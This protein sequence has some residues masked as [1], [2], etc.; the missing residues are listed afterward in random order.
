MVVQLQELFAHVGTW[1]QIGLKIFLD[2]GIALNLLGLFLHGLWKQVFRVQG[3]KPSLKL[4]F[5]FIIEFPGRL[6]AGGLLA[7]QLD[8]QFVGIIRLEILHLDVLDGV[9]AVLELLFSF[10]ENYGFSFAIHNNFIKFFSVF[11][12]LQN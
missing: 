4:L 10:Y 12:V 3:V 8:D 6:I 11:D 2:I 9:P 1:L 7:D 5:L